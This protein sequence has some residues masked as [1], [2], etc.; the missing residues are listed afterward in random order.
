M[1]TCAG[2]I[3]KWDTGKETVLPTPGNCGY[4][5]KLNKPIDP[6]LPL[7]CILEFDSDQSDKDY[8]ECWDELLNKHQ[9]HLV[10]EDIYVEPQGAAVAV[11][12]PEH[13]TQWL[14]VKNSTPCDFDD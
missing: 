7:H 2:D 9:V 5:H 1:T 10:A 14:P 13:L 8:E 12:L 6:T 3:T 11:Q 4:E